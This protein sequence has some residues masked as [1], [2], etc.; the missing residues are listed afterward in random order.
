MDACVRQR[1]PCCNELCMDLRVRQQDSFSFFAVVH[2]VMNDLWMSVLD[3]EILFAV[4]RVVIN[5]F[6]MSVL[7]SEIFFHCSN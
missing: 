7:D 4:L 6:W 2:V 3:R 5:G 1:D